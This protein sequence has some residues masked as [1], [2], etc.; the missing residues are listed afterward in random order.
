MPRAARALGLSRKTAVFGASTAAMALTS[1]AIA[2]LFHL[3]NAF[4]APMAVWIVAQPSRGLLLERGVYRLVGTL[5]GAAVGFALLAAPLPLPL[6]LML[7]A[8]WAGGCAALTH[9]TRAAFGYAALMAGLTASVVLL[10]SL[11]AGTGGAAIALARVICTLIGVICVMAMGMV[12]LPAPPRRELLDRVRGLSGDALR[13]LARNDFQD[14]PQG[15]APPADNELLLTLTRLEQQLDPDHA[16]PL[17]RS[18]GALVSGGFVAATLS[19]LAMARLDARQPMPKALGDALNRA[20]RQLDQPARQGSASDA[21]HDAAQQAEIFSPRLARLLGQLAQAETAGHAWREQRSA[22][23]HLPDPI[24]LPTR[25]DIPSALIAGAAGGVVTLLAGLLVGYSGWSNAWLPAMGLCTFTMVLSSMDMPQLLAPRMLQG[26]IVGV[27]LAA[28][29]RIGLMPHAEGLGDIV[30][31]LAP[32]MLFGGLARASSKTGIPALDGNMCFMLASQPFIDAPTLPGSVLLD[33][34]S[35]IA[36]IALVALA[37]RLLPRDPTRR[38]AHLARLMLRD[39]ERLCG[40]S[41]GQ[42]P[43]ARWHGRMYRRLLRL[44]LHVGRAQA[45]GGA[46]HA[47]TLG[48]LNLADSVIHLR[49]LLQDARLNDVEQRAAR[50]LLGA[51]RRLHRDPDGI[52]QA[53]ANLP[54][55]EDIPSLDSLAGQ[56]RHALND[57]AALRGG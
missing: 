4:W 36:S 54:P 33:A 13:Q 10:P 48:I 41:D 3:P 2:S 21:L 8:A 43:D 6:A 23:R 44:M 26:I 51:L 52:T 12:L 27:S 7:L 16:G 56:L 47:G 14:S 24:T 25:R 32:F 22:R 40:R 15:D 34:G 1:F 49:T 5:A 20:A 57:T 29:F 39:I 31:L 37:Y 28:A 18:S 30:L 46:S 35:L 42:P 17:R 11:A 55:G 53:L 9:L 45:A 38:A 19:L 50:Q